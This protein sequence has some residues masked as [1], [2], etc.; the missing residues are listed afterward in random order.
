MQKTGERLAD[1]VRIDTVGHTC[2]SGTWETEGSK[3]WGM[4]EK[5]KKKK[6]VRTFI[7]LLTD[8]TNYTW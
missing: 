2:N 7:H 3:K 4:E 1:L 6:G 8:Q 5:G